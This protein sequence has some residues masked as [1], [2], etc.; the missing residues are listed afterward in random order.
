VSIAI[1]V[2]SRAAGT[3]RARD[4][5]SATSLTVVLVAPVFMIVS[6]AAVQAALWSHAR[7]EVRLVARDTASLVAR[8]GVHPSA[9]AA[10]ARAVL[11]E[12]ADVAG[13][14]VV[15]EVDGQLVAVTVSG[16]APGIIRGTRSEVSATVA[17]PLERSNP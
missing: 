11:Q 6:F 8:S 5:G 14:E 16:R 17:L 12:G 15:I 10:S 1:D 13:V 7:T 2:R 3:D 4:R 9:A